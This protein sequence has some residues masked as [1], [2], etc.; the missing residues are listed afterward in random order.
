MPAYAP[1]VSIRKLLTLFV[2]IAVLFAPS[3]TR[4]GEALAAVPGHQMQMMD[5]GHCKSLPSADDPD[6]SGNH[7]KSG[8]H[9]KAAGKTCCIAMCMAV[10]LSPPTGEQAEIMHTT[11]P[12]FPSLHEYHGRI[13]EIATP[14]PRRA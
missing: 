14:P 9:D 6:R 3:M 7:Q 11:P 4:A 5:S 13:T 1:A 12:A 8:S 10:A 2:A